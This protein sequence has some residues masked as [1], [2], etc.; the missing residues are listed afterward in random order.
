MDDKTNLITS[1][2][3]LDNI[4]EKL[5]G[6]NPDDVFEFGTQ[7]FNRFKLGDKKY[8]F[9]H[10][11]GI[12]YNTG[13]SEWLI[14]VGKNANDLQDIVRTVY[15]MRPAVKIDDAALYGMTGDLSDCFLVVYS[16]GNMATTQGVPSTGFLKNVND[17]KRKSHKKVID[18]FSYKKEQL[19]SNDFSDYLFN[20]V[21][22]L[23]KYKEKK[24]EC[25]KNLRSF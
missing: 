9:D 12:L 2:Q 24:I 5:K 23:I 8:S 21:L 18:L 17:Y 20:E 13:K 16:N 22:E 15:A 11:D 10:T 3:A 7:G 1:I 6:K 4:F 14:T 25:Y 19:F